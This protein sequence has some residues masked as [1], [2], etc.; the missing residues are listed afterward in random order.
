MLTKK[1][2]N[3]Y[4]THYLLTLTK[5]LFLIYLMHQANDIEE[6]NLKILLTQFGYAY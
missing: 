1:S 3:I 5:R 2:K 6:E 4:N